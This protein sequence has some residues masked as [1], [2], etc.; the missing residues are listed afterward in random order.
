MGMYIYIKAS[1]KEKFLNE[2]RQNDCVL[3]SDIED[4]GNS[5]LVL[6][7]VAEDF[8][9]YHVDGRTRETIRVVFDAEY[10]DRNPVL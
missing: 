1:K 2:L 9:H 3:E 4:N 6:A 5:I 10:Y 7:N 8:A